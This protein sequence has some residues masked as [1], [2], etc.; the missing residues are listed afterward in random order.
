M[1]NKPC[2]L[3]CMMILLFLAPKADAQDFSTPENTFLHFLIACE[4]GNVDAIGNCL[5]EPCKETFFGSFGER[6]K[7]ALSYRVKDLVSRTIFSLGKKLSEENN[8]ARFLVTAQSY[9]TLEKKG[10]PE[11]T[12]R[13]V[14]EFNLENGVWKINKTF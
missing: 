7:I 5:T 8:R 12:D 14:F 4:T 9:P 6:D 2:L 3:I 13:G 11:K 10:L 1:S